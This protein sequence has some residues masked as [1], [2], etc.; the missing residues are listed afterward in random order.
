MAAAVAGT[1]TRAHAKL[2]AVLLGAALAAAAC[3]PASVPPTFPI[4]TGGAFQVQ[5]VDASRD[6]GRGPSVAIDPGGKVSVSYLLTTAAATPGVLPQPATPGVP[7]APSVVLATGT[8]STA[9]WS[10][11]AVTGTNPV[12]PAAGQASGIAGKTGLALPNV[13]TS[14]AVDAQGKHHVAWS[15]PS[16]LFYGDEASGSFSKPQ[17]VTS[18]QALGVSAAVGPD[19]VS[20]VSFVEGS[21]VKAASHSGGSWKIETVAKATG[22]SSLPAA[23]TS[24]KV[25]AAGQPI[26][27]FG[28]SGR[29]MVARKAGGAWKADA[30]GG[31]GGYAVSLAVDKSGNAHVALYDGQGGVHVA[32][33]SGSGAWNVTDLGS[34][35]AGSGTA[36]DPRW[37]T[38]VAVDDQGVRYLTWADTR[39]GEVMFATDRVRSSPLRPCPTPRLGSRRAWPSPPTARR[40]RWRGTTPT[41]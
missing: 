41:T 37:S 8:L 35:S 4:S 1:V 11:T 6:A 38:G 23:D 22:L 40:W 39:A 33:S 24:I 26:V 20:W 18:S 31:P 2:S 21:M 19:G 12:G 15:T 9:L 29:T 17:S 27:A 3:A 10:R 34:T 36:G 16:G 14:L 25:S 5:V 28:D 13:S 7:Y 32:D 30:I